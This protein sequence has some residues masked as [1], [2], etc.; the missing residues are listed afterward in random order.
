MNNPR[1]GGINWMFKMEHNSLWGGGWCETTDHYP[2]NQSLVMVSVLFFPVHALVLFYIVISMS[3][4]IRFWK[5]GGKRKYKGGMG[6]KKGKNNKKN[7]T[8]EG[9]YSG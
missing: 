9:C 8:R 3:K 1:G 6:V 2:M 4:E 7:K 5:W